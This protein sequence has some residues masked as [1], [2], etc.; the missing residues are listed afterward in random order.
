MAKS[1]DQSAD[2]GNQANIHTLEQ[3][4]SLAAG[5]WLVRHGLRSDRLGALGGIASVAT[6][7]MLIA[8]GLQG[9]C[10]LYEKLG[11]DTRDTSE[12]NGHSTSE[13]H[14]S[15]TIDRPAS[16]LYAR[17]RDVENLP[18]ILSHVHSVQAI[19]D[20]R[21]RWVIDSPTSDSLSFVSEI[22]QDI[23]NRRIAWET[24]EDAE[25]QNSGMVEF[26][27]DDS[28][29][30]DGGPRTEMVVTLRYEVPA[31]LLGRLGQWL[32]PR[33][34]KRQLVDDLRRFRRR[35]E[36]EGAGA[37][38][39]AGTAGR[40]AGSTA[41]GTSPTGAP[42]TTSTGAP[43]TTGSGSAPASAPFTPGRQ[44]GTGSKPAGA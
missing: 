5:V 33:H 40:T 26:L 13:V 23:P 19:D 25:V 34:P 29:D 8:R 31:G 36:E 30:G 16:E 37:E 32:L 6:G 38:A 43:G 41:P 27:P 9:H 42:G 7:G 3:V 28:A 1:R 12:I 17:W 35:M 44:S 11:I 2:S 39:G 24:T 10:A 14:A 21:S 18:R 22:T 15:V 20:R 4:A